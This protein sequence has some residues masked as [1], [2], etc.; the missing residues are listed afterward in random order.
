VRTV[1]ESAKTEPSPAALRLLWRFA[2]NIPGATQT[3][4]AD[5][6]ADPDPQQV[7]DAAE[8]E[9]GVH[10]DADRATRAETARRA[11]KR[12]REDQLLFGTPLQAVKRLR[13]EN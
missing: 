3:G 11:R 9:L 10:I 12:L 2:V 4:L 5:H 1:V 8:A 6:D 13:A 7:I